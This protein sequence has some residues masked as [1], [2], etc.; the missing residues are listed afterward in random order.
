V[1]GTPIAIGAGSLAGFARQ[2]DFSR[3]EVKAVMPKALTELKVL[4]E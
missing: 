1:P 2:S 4:T 3:E